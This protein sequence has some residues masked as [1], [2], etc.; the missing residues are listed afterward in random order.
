M[1]CSHLSL[2]GESVLHVLLL[3]FSHGCRDGFWTR[4]RN[5]AGIAKN[6]AAES[7]GTNQK[8]KPDGEGVER[9]SENMQT[10]KREHTGRASM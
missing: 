8:R 4:R 7:D 2:I 3:R 9:A 6:A 5:A 10:S 1:S